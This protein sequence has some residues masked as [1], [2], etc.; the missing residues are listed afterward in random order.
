MTLYALVRPFR[1]CVHQ[2]S[3]VRLMRPASPR[4]CCGTVSTLIALRP[5]LFLTL[6]AILAAL[7]QTAPPKSGLVA[8]LKSAR[9]E[10]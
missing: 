10:A 8:E 5:R 1:E 3:A 4:S 7:R 2:R 9:G 6:H